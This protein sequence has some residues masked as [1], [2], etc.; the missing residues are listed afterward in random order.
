MTDVASS[1]SVDF[2]E[3]FKPYENQNPQNYG[4]SLLFYIK[5]YER[6]SVLNQYIYLDDLLLNY[7]VNPGPRLAPTI[8][9][10]SCLKFAQHA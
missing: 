3:F 6:F 2:F 1:T 4:A 10:Q 9:Q 7:L 8:Q 5:Y